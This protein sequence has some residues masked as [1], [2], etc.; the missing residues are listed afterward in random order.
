MWTVSS[1]MFLLLSFASESSNRSEIGPGGPRAR[2]I[3]Y[4]GRLS[5]IRTTAAR[6]GLYDLCL[7]AVL[8]DQMADVDN[9]VQTDVRVVL[10]FGGWVRWVRGRLLCGH[11]VRSLW[12]GAQE[13]ATSLGPLLYVPCLFSHRCIEKS[14]HLR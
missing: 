6:H 1:V 9:A 8:F 4:R 3:G 14:I 12:S 7:F 11:R 10:A 2:F 5:A 13:V